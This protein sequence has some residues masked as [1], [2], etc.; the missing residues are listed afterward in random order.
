MARIKLYQ[1]AH[2]RS[3]DKGEITNISLF[4]YREEDY[5]QLCLQVTGE[6]VKKHF[7]AMVRGN[8]DRYELPDLQ[9]LHFVLHGTRPGGVAAALDLDAHGKS[10]SWALLQMEIETAED[11]P[12]DKHEGRAD[13]RHQKLGGEEY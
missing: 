2:S 5:E 11:G 9:A 8:V 1:L 6:A 13:G 12:G 7:G 4:S 3:G 10:L